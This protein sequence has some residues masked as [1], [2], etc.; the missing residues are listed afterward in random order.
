MGE[1]GWAFIAGKV[2]GGDKG[3]VQYN[4]G[5]TWITG[6]NNF[7]YL[8]ES[9]TI[10]V[11]SSVF[12]SGTLFANDYH[13]NTI[14][15]TVTNL[16]S[17][18][19]SIFGN[20]ADDTH[21]FTGSMS[22]NG[23]FELL[24]STA[25]FSSSADS[26][27]I[28]ELSGTYYSASN[29]DVPIE[30]TFDRALSPALVV[31]G[32]AVFNDP[33]SI[34]GGLYGASPIQV[35]APMSFQD[36]ENDIN[37]TLEPGKFTG[38]L[39]VVTTN[40]N[41]GFKV[42]GPGGIIIESDND[43]PLLR[44]IKLANTSIANHPNM[45]SR[46]SVSFGSF[47][48]QVETRVPIFTGSNQDDLNDYSL[49][50]LVSSR[51]NS[52]TDLRRNSYLI[53]FE[54]PHTEFDSSYENLEST[55]DPSLTG[56]ATSVP[57]TNNDFDDLSDTIKVMDVGSFS[58]VGDTNAYGVRRGMKLA[59]NIIPS[60]I[61]RT[62]LG[63]DGVPYPDFQTKDL[64]IGHP[65]ARWGDLHVTNDRKIK[66][67][68]NR[69]STEWFLYS[70]EQNSASLGYEALFDALVVDGSKLKLND[71]LQINS[72]G[73]INFNQINGTDGYGF[74]DNSGTMQFKNQTGD[75]SGFGAVGSSGSVQMSDGSGGFISNAKLSFTGDTLTVDGTI[76][77]NEIIVNT[78]DQTVVNISMTG[79]TSFGDTSDDIHNFVGSMSVSGSLTL[80][81]KS[82]T[83]NYT[84]LATDHFVGID[85][86]TNITIQLPLASEL[87]DGQFFTIK[88]ENGAISKQI[89]LQ[90]SGSDEIDGETSISLT[91]PYTAINFYSNGQNKYFIF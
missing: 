1:I 58:N 29:A 76:V 6:S 49:Q 57:F 61:D 21:Q 69:D 43:V 66:W 34:Q 16:S 47:L 44:A 27:L 48:N 55:N 23:N 35:Y 56:S 91:S 62:A 86:A 10:I 54:V 33:V 25:T 75:W 7:K 37:S 24:G 18:G 81:R 41:D 59:G 65:S 63:K 52:K 2:A 78:I 68:E 12:V 46:E 72:N 74:R 19:S 13:V 88:D 22:I 31:S 71:D 80:N 40:I 32:T 84:L 39:E 50:Q 60:A 73:Y 42:S 30:A 53:T 3:A 14:N 38:D 89:I 87:N 82:I 8:E 20:T 79:S 90:C 85:S 4:D 64:T 15:E 17:Q 36:V 26:D 67:G 28:Y 9:N 77:A 11:S 5:D 45:S 51:V 83:N 70:Q